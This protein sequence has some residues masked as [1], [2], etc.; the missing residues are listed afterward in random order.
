MTAV[1]KTENAYSEQV[2]NV[3]NGGDPKYYFLIVKPCLLFIDYDF[4]TDTPSRAGWDEEDPTP[5]KKSSWD[6]STPRSH[7]GREDRSDRSG[8]SYDSRRSSDRRSY[9]GDDRGRGRS[10]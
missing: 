1:I 6:L 10:G 3:E 9:K 2:C 4:I 5:L 7:S 8:R